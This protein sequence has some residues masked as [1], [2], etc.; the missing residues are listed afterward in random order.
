MVERVFQHPARS[1][2]RSLAVTTHWRFD[3]P[4]LVMA[5]PDPAKASTPYRESTMSWSGQWATQSPLNQMAVV[6]G[7]GG[8]EGSMEYPAVRAENTSEFYVECPSTS[9]LPSSRPSNRAGT[10][11]FL[12]A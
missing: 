9:N 1:H 8:A 10:F 3:S 12:R 4:E 2:G 5:F 7:G 11:G 6:F